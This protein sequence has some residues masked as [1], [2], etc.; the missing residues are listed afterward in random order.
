MGE[1]NLMGMTKISLQYP[2]EHYL[3]VFASGYE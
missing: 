1:V 2:N 3:A